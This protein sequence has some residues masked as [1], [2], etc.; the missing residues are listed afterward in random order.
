GLRVATD[1][2]TLFPLLNLEND[3]GHAF[4]LGVE[5]A[6]AQIAWQL[7]KRYNQDEELDWGCAVE[8]KPED[9]TQHHAPGT[10]LQNRRK[11]TGNQ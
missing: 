10:T 4:Y 5:L 7:A 1:P 2:F 6:R 3:A 8:R 11:K 9:L